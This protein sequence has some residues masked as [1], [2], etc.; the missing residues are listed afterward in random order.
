MKPLTENR[1]ERSQEFCGRFGFHVLSRGGVATAQ[2]VVHSPVFGT[3]LE[4]PTSGCNGAVV[5]TP[6]P[7]QQFAPAIKGEPAGA[8]SFYAQA[9]AHHVT[10]ATSMHCTPSGRTHVLV[11]APGQAP[12]ALHAFGITN[13]YQ[14]VN[15]SGYQDSN[16]AEYVQAGWTV[17]S[18]S[19]PP[20]FHKYSHEGYFA[21]I[22]SG[23]GGGFG[24]AAGD[25]LIQS[26]TEQTVPMDGGP[27]E[28]TF[29]YEIV[30][31]PS[32]TGQEMDISYGVQPGDYVGTTSIWTPTDTDPTQGTALFGFCNF[33]SGTQCT[34]MAV[35][36]PTTP[37]P[38]DTTE[39]IVEAPS[40]PYVGVLPLANFG[41]VHFQ[42]AGWTA[43]WT[44]PGSSGYSIAQGVSPTPITLHQHLS[45]DNHEYDIF[46]FPGSLDADGAGFTDT[47]SGP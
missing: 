42:A 34:Q 15:W 17:P 44:G 41:S 47:F 35:N 19:E 43:N 5:L 25:P 27:S 37:Q 45:Y 11:P 12:D 40:S 14:S 4:Y 39:W 23:I 18:V 3:V 22:W 13:D 36:S 7:G 8:T 2:T 9:A 1:H 30:G 24:A 6:L 10:W 46:A 29:W 16:T 38:G 31:G 20:R 33:S 28:Y 26:G 32:D 21:S